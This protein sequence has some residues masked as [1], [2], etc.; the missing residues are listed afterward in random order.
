MKVYLLLKVVD[1]NL[2]VVGSYTLQGHAEYFSDKFNFY[3]KA[4]YPDYHGEYYVK[5]IEL[6]DLDYA[7][8]RLTELHRLYELRALS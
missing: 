1:Q 5:S 3:H 8:K 2:Y 7:D 6:D 4:I